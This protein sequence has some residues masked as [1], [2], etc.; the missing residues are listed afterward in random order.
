VRILFVQ[1]SLAPPGGGNLVAA[2]ML[3]ALRDEHRLTLLTWRRPDLA[4]CNRF[5]G[6]SLR[7]ADL[8]VETMPPALAGLAALT[9]T[10]MAL[11]KHALL[12]RRAR[13]LAPRHDLLVTAD[14][15]ADL[16]SPGVQYVH[17]PKF[18]LARPA[19][20]LR[21]YH[22]AP[23]LLRAYYAVCTRLAGYSGE[24]MRAN[25]TLVNS[26]Y[27]GRQVRALHGVEP[28]VLPPPA[29]G[30]FPAVP[31]EARADGFVAIGRISP[32]KRFEEIIDILARVRAAGHA[33]HLHLVGTDDH[34]GY[35]R[36]IRRL[37]RAHAGWVTRHEGLARADLLRL[38][39]SQRYGIHAMPD[40]HYG[41]AVAEMVRGGCVT[42]VAGG[43]GPP[44]IVGDDER[45]VF[46]S[47]A[48]A[49]ARIAAVLGDPE[50]RAAVRARL[51][52]RAAD[53]APERFA[54]RLRALV[55]QL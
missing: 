38:I 6:T 44:E 24:R 36:R 5:F 37:T 54:S 11:L 8:A 32:E 28:V 17:Y 31:W 19:V 18:G 12:V 50:R 7:P 40:E 16:G 34:P 41:I 51:A 10:P 48:D 30:D 39:A 47:P 33:V 26:E 29:P 9:P 4:A 13:A 21:W 43:G 55:R 15:E 52:A 2:W 42:F 3:E 23:A 22:S 53:L 27:I 49:A 45:L 46:G 25:L 35:S 20:D 1:P 14:N